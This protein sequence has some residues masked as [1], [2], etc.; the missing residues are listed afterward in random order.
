MISQITG[1]KA[2][3]PKDSFDSCHL[4]AA[5]ASRKADHRFSLAH[6]DGV[7][8]LLTSALDDAAILDTSTAEALKA[9]LNLQPIRFQA[10]AD[11]TQANGELQVWKGKREKVEMLAININVYG[12]REHADEVGRLLSKRQTYL[13]HPDYQD[14]DAEYLNPHYFKLPDDE[15]PQRPAFSACQ[16][17]A[18]RSNSP[19]LDV[20]ELL[21]RLTANEGLDSAP[22]DRRIT[23]HLLE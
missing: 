18:Q 15:G 10:Y 9:L 20:N 7:F 8:V 13:Q 5:A 6:R 12:S 4:Q 17:S 21:D 16:T 2:G 3:A 23:T 22:I 11:A 19:E 1:A 14:S